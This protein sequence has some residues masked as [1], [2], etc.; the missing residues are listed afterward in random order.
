ML[1]SRDV[2][3]WRHVLC[4][5]GQGIAITHTGRTG[6][7]RTRTLHSATLQS[8]AGGRGKLR[9]QHGRDGMGVKVCGRARVL[10]S[11]HRSPGLLCVPAPAAR[12]TP[13]SA[14]P[15]TGHCT[16]SCIAFWRDEL[17]QASVSHH[18]AD[19]GQLSLARYLRGPGALRRWPGSWSSPPRTVVSS[20]G[21]ACFHVPRGGRRQPVDQHQRWADLAQRR[22]LH[23]PCGSRWSALELR[24]RQRGRGQRRPL[25]GH[26]SRARPARAGRRRHLLRRARDPAAGTWSAGQTARAPCGSWTEHEVARRAGGVLVNL[27]AR[28][29][30]PKTDRPFRSRRPPT[31]AV[32]VGLRWRSGLL[33]RWT[34]CG[35]FP[36]KGRPGPMTWSR[37]TF[38][39]HDGNLWLGDRAERPCAASTMAASSACR[40]PTG[41]P[42]MLSGPSWRTARANLWVGTTGGF[43]QLRDGKLRTITTADGLSHDFVRS[44]F[45]DHAGVLWVGTQGGG[46]KPLRGRGLERPDHRRR[47]VG[48]HRALPCTGRRRRPVDRHAK[49]VLNRLRDGRLEVFTVVDGLPDDRVRA[50]YADRAG[51]L[52]IGTEGGRSRAP[53]QRWNAPLHHRRRSGPGTMSA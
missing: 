15:G 1:S 14:R 45:E 47:P 24:V 25:G 7:F 43:D 35:S 6:A 18:P 38:E 20:P 42:T 31:G 9:L 11:A 30:L 8:W 37:V 27:T 26:R 2:R 5:D 10:S 49:T 3:W 33:P 51:G 34:T 46:L 52:W 17:P 21:R 44:V 53:G 36:L 28:D 48:R 16:S 50:L 41:S 29:G 4:G 13:R 12:S 39:D 40:Q 19:I 22:R 23:H 32:W